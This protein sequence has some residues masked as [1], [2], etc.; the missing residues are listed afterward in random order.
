VLAAL[1]GD[2]E[3]ATPGGGEVFSE[4]LTALL[5]DILSGAAPN[6]GR[7]CGDCYHPLA[8]ERSA[9]PHC[10]R[11]AAEAA[12]VENVPLEV[13]EMQRVRRS[14][15]GLVV[16]S[17]AWAGLTVGV[18]VAL[19]PLAFGGVHWWSI[20]SFFG[21]LAFFYLFS[22]NLANS[23]GD[24]LGYRWGLSELRRR[25]ARFTAQRGG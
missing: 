11:A 10:G 12:P 18:A 15:E 1:P 20:G 3:E 22:A 17:V 19:V 5:D 4:R 14:R 8:P 6:A 2:G 24:A 13:I 9:C 25:W 23:V 16:R 7:F 21:L